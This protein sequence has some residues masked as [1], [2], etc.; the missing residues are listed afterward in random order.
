MRKLMDAYC[1]RQ[2]VSPDSLR[3]Y[4]PDGDRI[5]PEKTVEEVCRETFRDN[6]VEE[7]GRVGTR[8]QLPIIPPPPPHWPLLPMTV[9]NYWQ[10]LINFHSDWSVAA[11]C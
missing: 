7:Y 6:R 8:W 3:F 1:N 10:W 4:T 2:G 5:M 11:L 9:R